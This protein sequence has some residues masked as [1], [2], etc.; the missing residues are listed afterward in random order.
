MSLQEI[1]IITIL[2]ELLP[3]DTPGSE[4]FGPWKQVTIGVQQRPIRWSR[5][6]RS[7]SQSVQLSQVSSMKESPATSE[8]GQIKLSLVERK[9]HVGRGGRSDD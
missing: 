7:Q 9:S 8:A 1:N 6:L 3:F 5:E 4:C 2:P